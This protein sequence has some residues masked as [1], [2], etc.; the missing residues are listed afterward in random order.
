MIAVDGLVPADGRILKILGLLLCDKD[1]DVFMQ[2]SLIALEREDEIGLLVDDLFS[3]GALTSHGVDGDDCAFN[4]HHVEQRRDG[5]DL[6]GFQLD[7]SFTLTCPKTR[8]WRAAKADTMWIGSF[9][10]FF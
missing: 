8:R 2:G 7:F 4:R 10:L 6:V 9:E 5:D 3:D 1:L